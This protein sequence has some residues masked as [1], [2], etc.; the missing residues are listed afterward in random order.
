[1]RIALGLGIAVEAV[2]PCEQ[3][4]E[5]NSFEAQEEYR[6][7]LSQCR[8]VHKLPIHTCSDDAYLA[9]GL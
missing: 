4:E 1:M 6:S 7:L 3:Y 9:N 8:Q 5:K 2:I